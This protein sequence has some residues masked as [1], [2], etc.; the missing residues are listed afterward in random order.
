[1]ICPSCGSRE[2]GYLPGSQYYCWNCF[3]QFT[4]GDNRAEVYEVE[5]DGSLIPLGRAGL[6]QLAQPAVASGAP[7]ARRPLWAE[8]PPKATGV[9]YRTPGR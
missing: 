3:V 5:E 2:V 4:V 7:A 6:T 8:R 1:V 9:R